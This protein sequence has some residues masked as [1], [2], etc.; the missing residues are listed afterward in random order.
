MTLR[1]LRLPAAAGPAAWTLEFNERRA[2]LRGLLG[3]IAG[4]DSA[5][6]IGIADHMLRECARAY[7]KTPDDETAWM[8]QHA[9]LAY[10]QELAEYRRATALSADGGT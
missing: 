5:R 7:A 4:A 9:A 3:G 6:D 10:A 8:L 2:R 1:L